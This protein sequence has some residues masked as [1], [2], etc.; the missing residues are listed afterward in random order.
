MKLVYFKPKSQAGIWLAG[1]IFVDENGR[2]SNEIDKCYKGDHCQ[3][4][5]RLQWRS[6]VESEEGV[7]L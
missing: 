1:Y 2:T 4:T 7:K 6:L 5:W 3:T